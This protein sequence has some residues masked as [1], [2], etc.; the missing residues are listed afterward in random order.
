[1]TMMLCSVLVVFFFFSF[2]RSKEVDWQPYFT[3]RL[4]DD[5]ATH[6]RVFRKAQE[7]LNEREDPKQR[8]S[9][10]P[11][12]LFPVKLKRVFTGMSNTAVISVNV[13]RFGV[14]FAASK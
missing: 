2:S 7:R 5:F 8:E 11:A 12:G 6:L 3:T 1:M 10:L 4:V 14:S 9:Q 13:V